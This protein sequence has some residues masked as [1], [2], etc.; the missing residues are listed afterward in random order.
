MLPSGVIAPATPDASRAIRAVNVVKEFH[1]DVGLRRVLD[2]I[3]FTVRPGD[4]FAILGRNGAGKSTLI[5]ILSGIMEPTSGRVD[6][7]MRLSW[8]LA[9]SGGMEGYLTG[10]DNVRFICSLYGAPFDEVFAFVED[11]TEMGKLLLLPMHTY[12]SGMVMR[13]AFALSMAID[14]DCILIDEVLFVGD[15]RFQRKCHHELFEKRKDM[16]MI[17]AI[18]SPEFVRDFCSAALVLKNGKGRVFDDVSLAAD[19]YATL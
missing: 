18:H 4:R 1:T 15:Q 5:K 2:G 16:A 11:F 10:Y 9:L 12:S 14:F 17:I 7:G 8:P 3:N 19:I 6:L 13:V